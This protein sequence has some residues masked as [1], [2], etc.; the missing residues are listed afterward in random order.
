MRK[1]FLILLVFLLAL[2]AA[3]QDDDMGEEGME[4]F[5]TV[6]GEGDPV[7]PHGPSDEWDGRFTDPGA[8]LY[9]DGQFH[10]FR[11]GFKAW[12]ASVQIGYLTSDDGVNWTEVT[13]EP[14]MHTDDVPFAEV[15]ALASSALVGEDGT[16]VLYFYTWN[17]QNGTNGEGVIGRATAP[18]PTGPWTPDEEPVL[19]TG[20][21]GEWDANQVVAPSVVRTE[22]GYMMFYSGYDRSNLMNVGLATSEDGVEWTK[23]DDPETTDAPYAESDPVLMQTADWEGRSVHQPRVTLVDGTFYMFYRGF[24]SGDMKIGLAT[25]EDGIEW[26]KYDA[27]PVFL[28]DEI[29]GGTRFWFTALAQHEETF[30]FYIESN[31]GSGTNIYAS[32]HEGLPE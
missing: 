30:Y 16:W 21:E 25:S 12:P 10:M 24:R 15:A 20:S 5:F 1:L 19:L 4:S 9:H 11:N 17:T 28:P 2:P 32:T 8:A 27:N 13:E 6:H 7:S 29:P 18:D 22:D 31:S 14:V 26:T 23:Y 3:A